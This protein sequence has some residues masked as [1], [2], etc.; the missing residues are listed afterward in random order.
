MLAWVLLNAKS[1][2][3][4]LSP[5]SQLDTESKTIVHLLIQK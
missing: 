4:A 3:G 5:Y 2:K 1:G